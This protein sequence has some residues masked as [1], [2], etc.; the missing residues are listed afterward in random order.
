MSRSCNCRAAEVAW[1]DKHLENLETSIDI[2]LSKGT[3]ET[4]RIALNKLGEICKPAKLA[5]I[6]PKMIKMFRRVLLN[7]K[8]SPNTINKHIR[9]IRSALSYAVRDGYIQSN[10]L[11]GPHRLELSCNKV[12]GRVLEIGEVTA[13]MNA[14]KS[15]RDKLVLSLAY[16]HGLGK[17][18]I[19]WL[20]WQDVDVQENRLTVTDQEGHKLKTKNRTRSVALRSETAELF[21]ELYPDRVNLHVFENPNKAY[22]DIKNL[23]PILAKEAE[24]DPST[25]HDLRRT[26]NTAMK[27]AGVSEEVALQVIGNTTIVNRK[28]Y[29]A[30]L[31]AQQRLAVD[32]LP[33]VG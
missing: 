1:K 10:K 25:L 17:G 13:L 9:T 33:S 18:E 3:I 16:Y 7:K 23:V 14:A 31:K 24:L 19:V 15:L 4:Q 26:C 21:K 2:D 5:D 6:D 8:A 28:H 32:S 12:R 22:N 11:V 29:T 27:D 20:R 30:E